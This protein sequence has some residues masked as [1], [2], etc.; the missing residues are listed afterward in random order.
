MEYKYNKDLIKESLS[1]EQVFDYVA[2]LGGEPIMKGNMFISKTICHNHKG[3]G[4]YKLYYYDNTKLFKCYTDCGDIFDIFELTS[5]VKTLETGQ[6]YTLYDS[7][8]LVASYFGFSPD[9]Q[10]I[11]RQELEDWKIFN[12]YERISNINSSQIVELK[13][14]DKNILLRLP[15]PI[16]TPWEEEGISR[17]VINLNNIAYD[18]VNEGIVIPH[19]DIDNKLIGIRERTLIKEEENNGKYKPAIINGIMYRH[20]LGFNL[21]NL[22]NSK[23]NISLIKK[24]IVFE[25]EK[26][27]LL[28]QSYFGKENDISCACCGSSL[29]NYQVLLLLNLN[30]Q[31]IIIG[32]DKQFKEIDDDEWKRWVKK[33]KSIYQK[34]SS[35][36]Q[37]SFLFDK[38]TLLEYKQSPIDAGPEVFLELYKNRIFLGG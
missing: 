16:I 37:I 10:N 33:L 2:E 14:Y 3:E 34:Y 36:V 18:P 38:G 4:S 30:V 24:A 29:I 19:Y 26:S 31:E 32:F 6:E 27:T 7:L 11:S 9:V 21:Y 8:I 23:N 13:E 17:E 12:N 25:S 5:K 20:P 35:F 1:I 22:N 28:Y 15:H